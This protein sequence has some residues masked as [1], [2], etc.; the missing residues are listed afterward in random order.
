M[1]TP[2]SQSLNATQLTALHEAARR[3]VLLTMAG[4]HLRG[5]DGFVPVSDLQAIS[6]LAHAGLTEDELSDLAADAA[7]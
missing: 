5:G 7:E 3:L 4:Q 2:K 1:S 6:D